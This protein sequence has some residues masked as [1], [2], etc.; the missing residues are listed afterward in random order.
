MPDEAHGPRRPAA[1]GKLT[2]PKPTDITA[3]GLLLGLA[4]ESKGTANP[5]R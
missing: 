4:S 3:G 2:L 1:K 5:S